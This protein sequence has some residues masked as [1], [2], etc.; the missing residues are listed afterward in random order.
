MIIVSHRKEA[1]TRH[2]LSAGACFIR[3]DDCM[4]LLYAGLITDIAMRRYKA[5]LVYVHMTMGNMLHRGP[6]LNWLKSAISSALS[7]PEAPS[8]YP[9]IFE[10]LRYAS[11]VNAEL[12]RDLL[13]IPPMY[14]ACAMCR[15][16]YDLLLMFFALFPTVSPNHQNWSNI[17]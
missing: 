15:V 17:E 6:W 14:T 12:A 13:T 1:I 16:L 8:P 11:V 9:R 3:S 4:R 5:H 7:L 2:K 10:S